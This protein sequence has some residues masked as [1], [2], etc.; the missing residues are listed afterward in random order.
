MA[1]LHLE[2]VR[3]ARQVE[4]A[5]KERLA[6]LAE[7]AAQARREAQEAERTRLAAEEA[8]RAAE[9]AADAERLRRREIQVVGAI[10]YIMVGSLRFSLSFLY[11][12]RIYSWIYLFPL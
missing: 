1:L 8:Q 5:E 2:S 7:D 4:N 10:Q 6:K 12:L 3:R 9:E 11:F